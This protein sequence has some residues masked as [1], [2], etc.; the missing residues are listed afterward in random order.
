MRYW[1]PVLLAVAI[2]CAVFCCRPALTADIYLELGPIK[3][4]C[5]SGGFEEQIEVISFVFEC[6]AGES[7]GRKGG[8]RRNDPL[9]LRPFVF[10]KRVD[11]ASPLILQYLWSGASLSGNTVLTLSYD[12]GLKQ[13]A[14]KIILSNVVVAN[15]S[16]LGVHGEDPEEEITLKFEVVRV[17]HHA[18]GK[19]THSS[20]APKKDK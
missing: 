15:Y 17:E 18:G 11:S 16:L 7:E 19:M 9:P 13:S 6:E 5:E 14:L 12:D 4:E 3:G 20:N 2:F 10:T 1:K 8:A